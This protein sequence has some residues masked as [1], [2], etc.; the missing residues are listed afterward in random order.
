MRYR[1]ESRGPQLTLLTAKLTVSA[2]CREIYARRDKY[3]HINIVLFL[4]PGNV[5]PG[6]CHALSHEPLDTKTNTKLIS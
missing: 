1:N 6:F 2:K 4:I 5:F 3:M